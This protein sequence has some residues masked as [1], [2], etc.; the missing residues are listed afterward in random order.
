MFTS[1]TAE[2]SAV[3]T[4]TRNARVRRANDRR[5]DFR[6]SGIGSD[7]NEL[8]ETHSTTNGSLAVRRGFDR[9]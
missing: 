4:Q 1:T 8:N 2:Q 6:I 9:D 7:D 3:T 5:R